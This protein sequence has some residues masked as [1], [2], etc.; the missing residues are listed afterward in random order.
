MCRKPN[1]KKYYFQAL[2]GLTSNKKPDGF[3]DSDSSSDGR[4]VLFFL[5]KK[6]KKKFILFH[7]LFILTF[8][9]LFYFLQTK[10]NDIL[11]KSI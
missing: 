5:K 2:T 3:V 10:Q 9:F 11:L 8:L 6:I 1:G 4:F 7:R